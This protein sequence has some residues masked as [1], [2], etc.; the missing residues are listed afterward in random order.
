[1]TQS[2]R[3]RYNPPPN[4]PP[5]PSGWTPEPGW[6]PNPAWGPEPPGWPLWVDDSPAQAPAYEPAYANQTPTYALQQPYPATGYGYPPPRRRTGALWA[7]IVGV[8]AVVGMVLAVLLIAGSDLFGTSDEQQIR[9]TV[10]A[11]ETAYNDADPTS[12]RA[13]ICEDRRDEFPEEEEDMRQT[14]EFGGEI[15]LVIDR[16]YV[17]GDRA[18][19]EVSGEIFSDDFDETWRFIREED[20]WLW[21]GD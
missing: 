13:L 6:E 2:R 8:V 19:A 9:D 18:T 20:H 7:A 12:F 14:L 16:V 3:M 15:T 1:M 17:D 11:M 21:C 4:W 10:S 5:P